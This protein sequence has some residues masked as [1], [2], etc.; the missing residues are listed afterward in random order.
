MNLD[1][2]NDENR[3]ETQASEPLK[4]M[5]SKGLCCTESNKSLIG[6]VFR[7]SLRMYPNHSMHPIMLAFDLEESHNESS[8]ALQSR[9]ESDEHPMEQVDESSEEHKKVSTWPG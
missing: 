4:A 8:R 6:I 2:I 5:T 9:I 7:S 1:A 3:A